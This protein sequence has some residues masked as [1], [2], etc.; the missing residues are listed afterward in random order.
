[1]DAAGEAVGERGVHVALDV[2]HHVEHRLALAPRHVELLVAAVCRAAP[3][4][5]AQ[6]LHF[7]ASTPTT[8]AARK[9]VST[10]TSIT[11]FNPMCTSDLREVFM[12]MAAMAV[13]R[14]QRETTEPASATGCGIHPMLATPTRTANATANHGS[15][16][17]AWAA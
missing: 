8:S 7:H 13:T 2:R 15:T 10:T 16:G 1:A 3:D 9:S 11:G 14:N 12:P 4:G 5:D 6:R 17:A